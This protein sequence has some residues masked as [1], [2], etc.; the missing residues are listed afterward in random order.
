[1]GASSEL[2]IR[3]RSHALKRCIAGVGQSQRAGCPYLFSSGSARA[4]AP[5]SVPLT[6]PRTKLASLLL[7]CPGKE[8]IQMP[9]L[10]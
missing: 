9:I 2:W 7:L 10:A 8:D 5:L 3:D 6:R 4:S 1:M